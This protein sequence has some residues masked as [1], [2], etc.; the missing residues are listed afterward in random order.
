MA[1]VRKIEITSVKEGEEVSKVHCETQGLDPKQ[2]L[3]TLSMTAVQYIKAEQLDPIGYCAMILDMWSN[4]QYFSDVQLVRV[5]PFEIIT[6]N[7]DDSDDQP[8]Q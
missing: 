6:H 3:V 1:E 7:T 4:E 2:I 5:E 8:D